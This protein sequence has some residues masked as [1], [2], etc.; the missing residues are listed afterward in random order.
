MRCEADLGLE[1]KNWLRLF[2]EQVQ[3]LLYF[4]YVLQ[5]SVMKYKGG[6][7]EHF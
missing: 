6:T 3:D 1:A 2:L 4:E 7:D 5:S